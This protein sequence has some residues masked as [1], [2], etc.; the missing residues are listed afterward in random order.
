MLRSA[1]CTFNATCAFKACTRLF[2]LL[3]P[4]SFGL[5]LPVTKTFATI[6]DTDICAGVYPS[7]VSSKALI[8]VKPYVRMIRF[9]RYGKGDKAIRYGTFL[10]RL[11]RQDAA[12][13]AESN[14]G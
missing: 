7:P 12:A 3:I 10:S 14:A 13:A 11:G 6:A 5:D 9:I 4:Y 1:L 8:Y 2:S